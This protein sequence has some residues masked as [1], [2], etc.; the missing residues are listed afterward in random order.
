MNTLKSPLFYGFLLFVTLCLVIPSWAC[1]SLG[2]DR[3]VGQVTQI[4]S[5]AGTFTILDAQTQGPMTFSALPEILQALVIHKPFIVTFRMT[6]HQME[7]QSVQSAA[8][9]G[10]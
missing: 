9:G 8:P 2:P 3:H 10:A 5:Q 6:D 7:A 1:D 4:D